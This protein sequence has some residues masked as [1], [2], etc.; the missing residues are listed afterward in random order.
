MDGHLVTGQGL[1]QPW[2]WRECVN[3]NLA[4]APAGKGSH[5]QPAGRA[6]A[7]K[8][9]SPAGAAGRTDP[10]R[11][12]PLPAGRAAARRG[13]GARKNPAQNAP[14]QA[15][16]SE[17]VLLAPEMLEV[18]LEHVAEELRTFAAQAR[19]NPKP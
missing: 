18:G 10:R 9:F 8:A 16:E 2:G 3:L 15:I 11:T 5:R 14:A 12:G 17:W 13:A 19:R 6:P 1:Q 7:P 4:S